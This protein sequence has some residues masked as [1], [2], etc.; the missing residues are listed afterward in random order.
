MRC[1]T[2]PMCFTNRFLVDGDPLI[3]WKRE[4]ENHSASFSFLKVHRRSEKVKPVSQSKVSDHRL[5]Y[6]GDNSR[7]TERPT[8]YCEIFSIM[9]KSAYYFLYSI[10]L[11]ELCAQET[12][13]L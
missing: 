4:V 2:I 1:C 6:G 11:E 10:Y 8:L 7:S 3:H 9:A 13:I 5:Q 12:D